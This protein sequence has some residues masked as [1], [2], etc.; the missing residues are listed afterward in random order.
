M[1]KSMSKNVGM[2]SDDPGLVSAP[3]HDLTEAG[4]GKRSSFPEPEFV[5]LAARMTVPDPEVSVDG[6]RGSISEWGRAVLPAL[7]P[8][9][10]Y[11][12]VEIDIGQS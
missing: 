8:D 2:Q 7:T 10:K 4:S 5:N 12:I 1:N 11:T 6:L 3:L 9:E